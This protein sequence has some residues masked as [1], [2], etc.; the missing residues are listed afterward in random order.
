[1]QGT[2]QLVHTQGRLHPLVAIATG[3]GRYTVVEFLGTY[4]VGVGDVLEWD[5]ADVGLAGAVVFRSRRWRWR[6]TVYVHEH[7]V[8]ASHLPRWFPSGG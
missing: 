4:K 5:E 2:V 8:P 6:R 7:R 1:M 3:D